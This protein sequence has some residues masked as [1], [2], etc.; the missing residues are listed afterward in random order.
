MKKNSEEG[1]GIAEERHTREKTEEALS[2][3]LVQ[4]G[5]AERSEPSW[6]LGGPGG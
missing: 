1:G 6:E 2:C 5:V 4:A 3:P